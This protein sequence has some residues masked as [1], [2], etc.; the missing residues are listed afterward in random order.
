MTG[1]F[2][3]RGQ[4]EIDFFTGGSIIMDYG[5]K[6]HFEVK[7]HNDGFVSYKHAAFYVTRY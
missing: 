1:D 2:E 7:H 3:V 6:Q 4:Q 5:Q